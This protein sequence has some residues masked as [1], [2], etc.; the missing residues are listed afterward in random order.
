MAIPEGRKD[1]NKEKHLQIARLV[2]Y[3]CTTI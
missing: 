1:I 3:E 2:D